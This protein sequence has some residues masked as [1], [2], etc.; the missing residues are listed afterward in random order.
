M[1]EL[2]KRIPMHNTTTIVNVSFE[3]DELSEK[4]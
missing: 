4:I 2:L 1:E 3:V